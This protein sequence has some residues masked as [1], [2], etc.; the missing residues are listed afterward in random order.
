MMKI[1]APENCPLCSAPLTSH[2]SET[3]TD[4]ER[5]HYDCDLELLRMEN[6]KLYASE[7]CADATDKAIAR[8]NAADYGVI[9]TGEGT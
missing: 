7:D 6:G 4:Y 8:L 2:A 3:E 5:W 9:P 1:T